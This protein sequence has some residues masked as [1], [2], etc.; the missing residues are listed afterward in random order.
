MQHK[1]YKKRKSIPKEGK[2]DVQSTFSE[3]S[4]E[5]NNYEDEREA[6][7]DLLY[8]QNTPNLKKE[9]YYD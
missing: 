2:I 3:D 9:R 6:I 1:E 7:A 5:F 4:L 8:F